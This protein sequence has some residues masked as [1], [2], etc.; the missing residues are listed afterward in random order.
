MMH[1]LPG[2]LRNMPLHWRLRLTVVMLLVS[3]LG[4]TSVYWMQLEA[5]NNR[6]RQ[7]TLD[8]ADQHAEQLADAVAHQA[9]D[10]FRGID[11][12]LR[13]MRHDYLEDPKSFEEAVRATLDSYPEG[14]ILN[15]SVFNASGEAVYNMV[16]AS[17]RVYVGDRDYFRA[18][19]ESSI[20]RAHVS[21]AILGRVSK[22]WTIPVS[23]KLILNGRFAGVVVVFLRAD[24][25]NRS[26]A[27][28][29]RHEGDVISLFTQEGAYL[30]RS[31][32]FEKA[33]GGS[34]PRDRPFLGPDAP[35][36][37]VL[38]TVAA[39]DKVSRV[40]GWFR[41]ED[42]PLVVVVGLDTRPIMAPIEARIEQGHKA[43]AL[44]TGLILLGLL[45]IAGLL[46]HTARQ[47]SKIAEDEAALRISKAAFDAASEGILVTDAQNHIL[48]VNPAFS[49]ITGYTAE[50]SIGKRPSML[51]SGRHDQDFYASIWGALN[52]NG[53]WEGEVT[54]LHKSGQLYCEWLKIN[55][56]D[57]DDPIR[58]RH[59]ALISDITARKRGE[60][61]V[62]RRAN[63][64]ELTGLPNRRLFVDRLKQSLGRAARNHIGMAVLFIDLDEF[65]P[66]NDRYGH[67]AG[68][69]L[70]KQVASRMTLCLR[71]EDTV[72]R[73]G[74]DEFVV[75]LATSPTEQDAL[76]A[77]EKLLAALHTPFQIDGNIFNIGASI[78]VALFPKHGETAETLLEKA[79]TAM[80]VAKAAGRHTVRFY[81]DEPYK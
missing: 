43:N 36:S 62:W 46:L 8:L 49:Q 61:V 26:L 77:A 39:Y 32:D 34:T 68:D 33:M 12:G 19:A 48:M 80:Y 17:G 9:G 15:I 30:S 78:G 50:E 37:G 64:D 81:S 3:V 72:A 73:H 44:G 56:I 71:E 74:G 6:L 57:K 52:T 59:V 79:D 2:S 45:L 38:R 20:D 10:L 13:H 27:R 5:S 41:L 69:E 4:L 40:Y 66:V 28:I 24:Y 67:Q 16:P 65:K 11:T 14:T 35:R 23:R 51:S 60:E 21:Q 76:A 54:N 58:R 55:V 1:R 70:L 75:M 31:A 53:Y 42:H 7:D 29:A 25:L 47:Q 22:A 18:Q 63:Y